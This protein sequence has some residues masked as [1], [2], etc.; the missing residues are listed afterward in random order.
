[1]DPSHEAP[2]DW[3]KRGAYA[4]TKNGLN[5]ILYTVSSSPFTQQIRRR[6]PLSEHVAHSQ[7][8]IALNEKLRKNPRARKVFE[9]R[10]QLRA[11]EVPAPSEPPKP[12]GAIGSSMF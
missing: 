10:L 2:Y 7:V 4:R 9:D 11:W 8:K 1:M 3:R 6:E 12:E 5:Q